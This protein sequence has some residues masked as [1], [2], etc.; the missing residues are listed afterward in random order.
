MWGAVISGVQAIAGQFLKNRQE[1]SQAKHERDIERIKA[2]N[3][4]AGNLT[5]GFKDEYWTFIL[6]FPYL[7]SYYGILTGNAEI[8]SRSEEM[9]Q[10]IQVL[11]YKEVWAVATIISI[12]VSFGGRVTDVIEHYGLGK[13]K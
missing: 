11:I 4:I 6:S 10:A 12:V 7:V 9:F 8:I 5:K 2:D 13:K 3:T 1:K